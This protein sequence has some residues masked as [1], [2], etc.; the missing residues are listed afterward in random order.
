MSEKIKRTVTTLAA[1]AALALGG[2]AIASAAGGGAGGSS[3]AVNASPVVDNHADGETNDDAPVA[4]DNP[5]DGETNDDHGTAS[6]DGL[7]RGE[8]AN[9]A[10]G[11]ASA[12]ASE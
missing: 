12:E 4:P 9:D 2:A 1:L 11:T 3:P 6:K 5:A 8:S 7:E 10:D